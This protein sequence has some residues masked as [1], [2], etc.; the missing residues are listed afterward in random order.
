MLKGIEFIKPQEIEKRS[1]ELLAELLGDREFPPEQAPIIKR[2]IHTT[3]DLEYADILTISENAVKKIKAA[4]LSGCNVVTDTK[5]AAAG[6]NKKALA[7]YGGEVIC[8][9][10]DEDIAAEARE[11]DVTRAAL[12]MDKAARDQSNRLFVIGNAPTALIRLYELITE[13]VLTTALV[14]GVPVGFVNVIES[15]AL[16]K[17]AGVPF[18]ISEGRKGGSNVAAAIVNAILYTLE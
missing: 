7:K 2:V 11:R 18:I 5:M 4:I 6:I 12:C 3:A 17:Q 13:G 1:F 10:E 14:I 16:I 8:Y 15:K 9:M